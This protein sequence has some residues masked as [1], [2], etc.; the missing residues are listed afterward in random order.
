MKLCS[1]SS[2]SEGNC[3]FVSGKEGKILVDAGIS[4][5]KIEH[6]LES[7]HVSPSSI[8]GIFVTHEHTDHI[9]GVGVMARR[10]HIPIYATVETMHAMLHGKK[11]GKV[12]EELIHLIKPDNCVQ[13]KDLQINPFSISHDAANPVAYTF[14]S[15]G[16]KIGIAT[17]L[18]DYDDYIIHNLKETE[19]LFIEANHDVNML[20]VGPYPYLLKQRILGKKGHLS[21]ARSGKLLCELLHKK[22]K[23]VILAHLSK[24]NNFPDLA[25]QTV[26]CALEE[27]GFI[28]KEN[29]LSV[30]KFGEPSSVFE[31]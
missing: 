14:Q 16:H 10:Y 22:L 15:E 11:I 23:H 18:G 2:G 6:G 1:I 5:K 30:A 21:N 29:F 26:R 31:I 12:P 20:Q 8:D 7:I 9:S 17:D 25:Y 28:C 13:I 27:N 19:L 24:E 4:G 3:I